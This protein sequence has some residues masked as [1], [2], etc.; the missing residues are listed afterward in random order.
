MGQA[1]NAIAQA[2]LDASSMRKKGRSHGGSTG[3]SVE[4][5]HQTAMLPTDG[6]PAFNRAVELRDRCLLLH[7]NDGMLRLSYGMSRFT[8]VNTER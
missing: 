3:S 2:R 4:E 1:I 6:P 5:L 8:T 7:M